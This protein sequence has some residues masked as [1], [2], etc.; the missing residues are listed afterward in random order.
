M[1]TVAEPRRLGRTG[2]TRNTENMAVDSQPRRAAS[3]APA[4]YG[5]G[6]IEI[7]F[8]P[9]PVVDCAGCHYL[10]AITGE[11]LPEPQRAALRC[12]SSGSFTWLTCAKAMEHFAPQEPEVFDAALR[13]RTCRGYEPYDPSLTT[14]QMMEREMQD[15]PLRYRIALAIAIL[16]LGGALIGAIVQAVA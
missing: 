8:R 7:A 11:P 9:G 12:R 14:A 4:T 10:S 1:P 16:L 3:Q 6:R 15:S 5:V 2:A 13:E